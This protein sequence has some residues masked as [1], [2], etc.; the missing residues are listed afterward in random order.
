MNFNQYQTKIGWNIHQKREHEE[1]LKRI[2]FVVDMTPA[3]IE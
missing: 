1:L 2:A 3:D